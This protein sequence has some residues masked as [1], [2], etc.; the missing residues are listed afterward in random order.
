MERVLARFGIALQTGAAL[1]LADPTQLGDTN[2]NQ[3]RA[4]KPVCYRR[5]AVTDSAT[6]TAADTVLC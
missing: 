3:T 5:K 4:N 2:R 1:L 6:K